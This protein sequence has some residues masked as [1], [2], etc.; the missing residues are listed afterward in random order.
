ML[1]VIGINVLVLLKKIRVD[2][3]VVLFLAR[4]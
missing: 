2:F 4:I 3:V 1:K